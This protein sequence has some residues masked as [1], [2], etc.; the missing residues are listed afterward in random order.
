MSLM[1]KLKMKMYDFRNFFIYNLKGRIF[2]GFDLRD[3]WSL[4]VSLAK[5][6]YPRLKY[7]IESEPQGFPSSLESDNFININGLEPYMVGLTDEELYASWI[8]ILEK[9]LRTF[10]ALSK[11]INSKEVPFEERQEALRLF[12][13]FY[14]AMWD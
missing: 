7:F 4:D 1:Y 8:I 13:L 6:I 12:A 11:G 9:I 14:E 3:T 2:Y 5:Q 10:E